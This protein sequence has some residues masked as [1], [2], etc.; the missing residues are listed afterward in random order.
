MS[1]ENLG[2]L[3]D[4]IVGGSSIWIAAANTLADDP[5]DIIIDGITPAGGYALAYQFAS[6]SPITVTATANGAGTGWTLEVSGAQTTAW[7]PGRIPFVGMATKGTFSIAVDSGVVDVA[8]SPLRVSQW[9]AVLTAVDAAIAQYAACPYG[10]ITVE[11]FSVAFRNLSDLIS[12][13]D[14]VRYLMESDNAK[15]QKRIIR[16]RFTCQ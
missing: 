13:R 11:G 4:A 15:K 10:T 1:L 9:A 12:L 5:E 7:G 16:A 3:P 14:Y 8:A 2:F 6:P